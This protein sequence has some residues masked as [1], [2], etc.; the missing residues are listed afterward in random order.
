MKATFQTSP[1][2]SYASYH[3]V[4][5]KNKGRRSRRQPDEDPD[6]ELRNT[7]T[8]KPAWRAILHSKREDEEKEDSVVP[9]GDEEEGHRPGAV[10]V[11]GTRHAESFISSDDEQISSSSSSSSRRSSRLSSRL[12]VARLAEQTHDEDKQ[13]EEIRQK[14]RAQ[15]Q[16]EFL[17]QVVVANEDRDAQTRQKRQWMALGGILFLAAVSALVAILLLRPDSKSAAAVRDNPCYDAVGL[18]RVGSSVQGLINETSPEAVPRCD[19]KKLPKGTQWFQLMGSGSYVKAST[20]SG[21]EI[22]TSLCVFRGEDCDSLVNV[23]YTTGKDDFC[24]SQSLVSWFAQEDTTYYVVVSSSAETGNFV[25]SMNPGYANDE[26]ETAY[27]PL[28]PGSQDISVQT[29]PE[30]QALINKFTA[31]PCGTPKPETGFWYTAKGRRGKG[32][33]LDACFKRSSSSGSPSLSVYKSGGGRGRGCNMLQ[34]IVGEPDDSSACEKGTSISWYSEQDVLY[35]IY[36]GISIDSSFAALDL[37]LS[38]FLATHDVCEE[39]EVIEVAFGVVK[40]RG[41]TKDATRVNVI[42]ACERPVNKGLWYR[43]I[44]SGTTM[45]ASVCNDE[46]SPNASLNIFERECNDLRC[47][48]GYQGGSSSC[49]IRWISVQGVSYFALVGTKEAETEF[50][51][52]IEAYPIA[53]NDLCKDALVISTSDNETIFGSTFNARVN[54][55]AILQPDVNAGYCWLHGWFTP[56]STPGLWYSVIG[57]GKPFEVS[58]LNRYT[59]YDSIVVVAKGQCDKLEC[60]DASDDYFYVQGSKSSETTIQTELGEVYYILVSGWSITAFEQGWSGPDPNDFAFTTMKTLPPVGDFGLTVREVGIVTNDNCENAQHIL[61]TG[62]L[63]PG[64]SVGASVSGVEGCAYALATKG[65]FY[66]VRGTGSVMR[67]M[68]P[69]YRANF[70][71]LL[72]VYKGDCGNLECVGGLTELKR[73]I[74]EPKATVDWLSEPGEA[75]F[76]HV[77]GVRDTGSFILQVKELEERPSR[78][79][80]GCEIAESLVLGDPLTIFGWGAAAAYSTD[81]VPQCSSRA[82]KL[83]VWYKVSQTEDAVWFSSCSSLLQSSRLIE[84]YAGDDCASLSCVQTFEVPCHGGTHGSGVVWNAN[85]STHYYVSVETSEKGSFQVLATTSAAPTNDSCEKALPISPADGILVGSTFLGSVDIPVVDRK[86]PFCGRY[87]TANA[88]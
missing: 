59:T 60:M 21:T 31:P 80:N 3:S 51:L 45:R 63:I 32:L 29:Q 70:Y 26:C 47:V 36:L 20:C 33:R 57:T 16:Q 12:P 81:K 54:D 42:P 53:P 25:L 84:V 72:S 46:G 10:R 75:Y 73:Y 13:V 6:D 52:V 35:Y 66:T 34:C 17:D 37:S 28:L 24:G 22:N 83:S 76:I 87:D 86:R 18:F 43:F 56:R 74:A 78:A 7:G 9:V 62:D 1:N 38:E 44:G 88:G 27:G 49:E 39:A 68:M 82:K 15:T 67:A 19:T 40:L 48:S 5:A 41:S 77:Y 14:A 11:R 8:Q 50:A 23:D 64:S 55:N 65:V 61:P 71:A 85:N 58:T 30:D 79:D 69:V 2:P 4:A